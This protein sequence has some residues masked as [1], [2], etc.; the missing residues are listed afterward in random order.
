MRRVELPLALPVILTGMRIAAVQVIATEPLGAF[1][2]GDG[3]GVYLRQGLGN[4]DFH[5][6]QAGALPRAPR[7]AIGVDFLLY[8]GSAGAGLLGP[9]AACND[10]PS[11]PVRRRLELVTQADPISPDP[12]IQGNQPDA[13]TIPMASPRSCSSLVPFALLVGCLRRR[14]DSDDSGG[15]ERRLRRAPASS[16]TSG[17][18]R[19]TSP[20]AITLTQVYAQFL[21]AKGFKHR[22]PGRQRASARSSTRRS[23]ATRPTSSSTTPAARPRSSTRRARRRPTRTRP[24]PGWRRP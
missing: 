8:L 2:G 9:R 22:G 3:L 24:T 20:R 16:T 6:V 19:R 12:Q 21:E 18:S 1:F 7:R 15:S 17:S 13:I 10:T 23:R 11:S 14:Q 5:E 4:Q